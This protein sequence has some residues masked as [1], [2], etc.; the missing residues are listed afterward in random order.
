M[1]WLCVC[2]AML[3]GHSPSI[4]GKTTGTSDMMMR[5]SEGSATYARRARKCFVTDRGPTMLGA[6]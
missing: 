6:L 4:N 2:K 3:V 1:F 5:R